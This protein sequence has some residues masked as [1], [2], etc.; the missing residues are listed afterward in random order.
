MLDRVVGLD[1]MKKH[2]MVEHY[3]AV[4]EIYWDTLTSGDWNESNRT[5]WFTAYERWLNDRPLMTDE[6]Q[7]PNGEEA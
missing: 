7:T 3:R 5:I 4:A 2:S 6:D 1:A